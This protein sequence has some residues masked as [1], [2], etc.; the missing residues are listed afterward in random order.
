MLWHIWPS[1]FTCGDEVKSAEMRPDSRLTR[2]LL[3]LLAD[4]NPLGEY[5]VDGWEI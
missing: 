5:Q 3:V 2:I 4:R 1:S